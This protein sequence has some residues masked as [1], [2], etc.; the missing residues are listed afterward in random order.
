M[1]IVEVEAFFKIEDY[2]HV[3]LL[4]TGS[5]VIRD[6]T[7]Q[8][9]RN[10]CFLIRL[11]T[12]LARRITVMC[13]V[14]CIRAEFISRLDVFQRMLLKVAVASNKQYVFSHEQSAALSCNNKQQVVRNKQ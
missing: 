1:I 2:G 10:L 4:V 9:E 12:M 14:L 11:H 13:T 3:F 7:L 6:G 8:R 5:N